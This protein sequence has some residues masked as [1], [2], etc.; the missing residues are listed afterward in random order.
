[1]ESGLR[2]LNILSFAEHVRACYVVRQ[3]AAGDYQFAARSLS[4]RL[5][6]QIFV[7]GRGNVKTRIHSC[8][9]H[10]S[11][12]MNMSFFGWKRGFDFCTLK[13]RTFDTTKQQRTGIWI[14]ELAGIA[15]A[16][17]MDAM[18]ENWQHMATRWQCDPKTGNIL[19]RLVGPIPF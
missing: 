17:K 9:K 4:F 15:T 16:D 19:R 14:H 8:M 18:S 5:R 1:L 13:K 7:Y 3:E 6:F 10:L 12:L 11:L 2:R